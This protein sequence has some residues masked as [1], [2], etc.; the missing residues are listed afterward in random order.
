MFTQ[1]NVGGLVAGL[2]YV[3]FPTAEVIRNGGYV[4]S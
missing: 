4:L 3:D 1:R 2:Q